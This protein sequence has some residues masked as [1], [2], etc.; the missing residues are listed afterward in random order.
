[1]RQ[2]ALDTE[3]TGFAAARGHRIVEIGCVE[4]VDRA[5]SDNTF[6]YLIN[7]ERRIEADAI[8]IHG[9]SNK[10]VQDAPRFG[11]ICQELL[12]FVEDAQLIIHNAKFDLAFLDAEMAR[13]GRRRFVDESNCSVVDT[14]KMARKL[15]PGLD[16]DLDALSVRYRVDRS[17]R[18][19][20]HGALIDAE[21]LAQVYL[22]MT[23]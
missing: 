18:Q 9:I 11:D 13:L 16:N 3:T 5:V 1:M 23:K 19:E 17:S 10:Q 20:R 8:A 21:L 6:H 12:D 22:A 4:I 7:P 14:V 15:H 2:I